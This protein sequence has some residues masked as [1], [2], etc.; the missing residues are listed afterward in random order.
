MYTQ[1]AATPPNASAPNITP[2]A[3]F[4]WV[5]TSTATPT[6]QPYVPPQAPPPTGNNYF[7]DTSGVAWVSQN[8]GVWKMCRDVLFCRMYKTNAWAFPVTANSLGWDSIER[9]VYGMNGGT[10]SA[11]VTRFTVPIAGL[12]HFDFFMST[13]A[14]M[15][16]GNYVLTAIYKNGVQY[17]GTWQQTQA[18]GGNWPVVG[19]S[20][21]TYLLAGDYLETWKGANVQVSG[22]TGLPST[23][24]NF[25]Y[26][27]S[28]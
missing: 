7:T 19:G 15:A 9:D 3:G 4:L 12:Y 23:W 10:T 14:A 5:D 21:T 25:E 16:A 1:V 26:K 24:A 22:A 8:G 28:G 20:L 17:A 18:A 2:P 27:G 6:S 13:A 11:M